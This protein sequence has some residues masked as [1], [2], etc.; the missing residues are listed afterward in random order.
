METVF[1]PEIRKIPA[2]G[3]V[4][5]RR[6]LEVVRLWE[7]ETG[8]EVHPYRSRQDARLSRGGIRPAAGG[9]DRLP[10]PQIRP[11]SVLVLQQ[12]D[13]LVA[14]RADRF[15]VAAPVDRRPEDGYR[16]DADATH[17]GGDLRGHADVDVLDRDVSDRDVDES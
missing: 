9:E 14:G 17:V 6:E 16:T 10:L 2:E 3:S 8:H 13:C 1:V 12:A 7:R 15:R 4:P 5:R 11:C